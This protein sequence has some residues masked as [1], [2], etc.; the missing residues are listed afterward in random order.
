MS[1]FLA[2]ACLMLAVSDDVADPF[3][4]IAADDSGNLVIASS[5]SD[6]GKVLINT[7]DVLGAISLLQTQ[8]AEA[9]QTLVDLKAAA[10]G[11]AALFP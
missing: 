6:D 2:A 1:L 8:A 9:A 10:E 3:W 5:Q 4:G 7:V 11:S